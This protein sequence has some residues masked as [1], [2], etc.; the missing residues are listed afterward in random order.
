METKIIGHLTTTAEN[1]AP[2]TCYELCVTNG[3]LMRLNYNP[4]SKYK[5]FT[6][7]YSDGHVDSNST[8]EIEDGILFVDLRSLTLVVLEKDVEL[9]V[10]R[11]ESKTINFTYVNDDSCSIAINK[12]VP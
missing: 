7:V 5:K 4:N 3:C 11:Q 12:E 8:L 1:T 9:T 6:K 10:L 2:G